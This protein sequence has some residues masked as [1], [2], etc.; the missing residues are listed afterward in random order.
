MKNGE[1]GFLCS[2][3]EVKHLTVFG[4]KLILEH[5]II[6]LLN[7]NAKRKHLQASPPILNQ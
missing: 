7:D 2:D 1:K 6:Q 5:H 4:N 3:D